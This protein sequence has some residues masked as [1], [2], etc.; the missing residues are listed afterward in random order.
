ME[1]GNSSG[2]HYIPSPRFNWKEKLLHSKES[3]SIAAHDVI[4]ETKDSTGAFEYDGS[5][6]SNKQ[7]VLLLLDP[8]IPRTR[9]YGE[10]EK[11]RKEAEENLLQN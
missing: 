4:P 8:K 9:K 1:I 10:G 7:C 6:V 2:N 11:N 5:T 3:V